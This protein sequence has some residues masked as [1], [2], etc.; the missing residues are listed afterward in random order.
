[1]QR[2]AFQ[3]FTHICKATNLI[4]IFQNDIQIGP[5]QS[6]LHVRPG[7]V[8][9]S[10]LDRDPGGHFIGCA[11]LPHSGWWLPTLIRTGI[12]HNGTRKIL[13]RT[14]LLQ[15]CQSG[16]RLI[17]L[18]VDPAKKAFEDRF[19]LLLPACE[20]G[21]ARQAIVAKLLLDLAQSSD[22]AQYLVRLRRLDIPGINYFTARVC[23]ALCVHDPGL[24]RVMRTGAVV[25]ALPNGANRPGVDAI[26]LAR[27]G[28]SHRLTRN[29]ELCA[30]ACL[31]RCGNGGV[32]SRLYPFDQSDPEAIE[33]RRTI[34]N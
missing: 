34:E 14:A 22:C 32:L 23:P 30:W 20:L 24:V 18:L 31:G 26:H 16:S 19:R 8:L 2:N 21:L 13:A 10:V 29:P 28:V 9:P 4:R 3:H 15:N 33:E 11:V 7:R 6:G 12:S 17:D 27:F 1:M 5:R 25:V